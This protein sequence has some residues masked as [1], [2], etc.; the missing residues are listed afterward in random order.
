MDPIPSG[1]LAGS[2]H[3]L[4]ARVLRS[5]A[6]GCW[7]CSGVSPVVPF[8][9]CGLAELNLET[10]TFYQLEVRSQEPLVLC[11]C[12]QTTFFQHRVMNPFQ[13]V[14]LFDV[15]C[16]I[17]GFSLGSA[18]LGMMTSAFLDSNSLACETIRANFHAPVIQGSVSDISSVQQLHQLKTDDFSQLTSGFPCQ[19]YSCQGDMQGLRDKRGI[20]RDI[21]RCAWLLQ[22][23]S[24]LLECVDNVMK[25][26]ET[27]QLLDSY[28]EAVHMHIAKI[29][30]DL[31]DQWPTRR[32]RFW[33]LMFRDEIPELR[34]R[35]WP[36]C[37]HCRTLGDVMP[38][39][40]VWSDESE[41]ELA[42]TQVEM[43]V[44][45]NVQYGSDIRQL[46]PHHQAPT[47]LHSW[48][49]L[50]TACP[51]GC[52]GGP[53]S[54]F[55][56]E[57]G[58][59]RGF[60]IFSAKFLQMRH[61]HAEE[62]ALLCTVPLDYVFPPSQRAALCLLGQL[63]APLSVLW[64]QA[65]FLAHLQEHFWLQTSL[66]PLQL[67]QQYKTGLLQQR[68]HRWTLASMD[69]PRRISVSLDGIITPIAVCS[70]VTVGD[71]E[72]AE[73]KL[74]GW[75]H[76]VIVT[77]DHQR[78]PPWC[79]LHEH[80][81]YHLQVI[82]KKQSRPRPTSMVI[83][84][85]ISLSSTPPHGLGDTHIWSSMRMLLDLVSSSGRL[86]LPFI[87]YPFRAFHFL[88]QNI[89]EAVQHSWQRQFCLSDGSI[90]VIYE[91][92]GHWTLLIGTHRDGFHWR[93]FDG[94]PL[95]FDS[96][97]LCVAQQISAKLA[98]CLTLETANF[99]SA[100]SVLQTLPHTCGSIAL[101]NM[102]MHLQV[103]HHLS[104]AS[105]SQLHH[106]FLATSSHQ[107]GVV[108]LGKGQTHDALVPLLIGKGVPEQLAPERAQHIRDKLGAV[109]VQ[110]ILK[111]PNPWASLKAAASKPGKM[112]RLITEEEQ[113]D[114]VNQRALTKH[115]ARVQNP[116][117][118]KQMSLPKGQSVHLNPDLF[119]L[120][121]Q[122]FQ[123]A[124][125]KAVPQIPFQDVGADQHGLA[126]C[127]LE[128]AR[129]FL[130][131]PKSI[132]LSALALL[133]LDSPPAKLVADTGLQ[134]MV[135]PALC[136]TTAEHTIIMGHI[137]QLGDS[138]VRRKMAGK[139]SEPE[140]ILTQVMTFQVYKD[141]FDSDWD[142]LAQAPVRC[143]V[144]MM[145]AMQLCK[146]NNCGVDC[147]KYHPGIDETLD[148]VLSEV[149]SR[150]FVN[151]QGKRVDP[152]SATQFSVFVRVPESALIKILTTLPAGVYAEPRGKQPREQDEHFKVIWL[153]GATFSEASHQCRTYAKAV[154][155]VRLKNKYG[156][157]VRKT[158]EVAAWSKL[159]PGTDFVD[160]SIQKIYELFPIP[161]GTQRQAITQIL[162]DWSWKAR[163]LQPGKGN[164]HHMAWRVG[165]SM[166][167]PASV[168]TAFGSDVIISAVK[169]LQ[170]P[171]QKPQIYASAKTQKLLREQPGP[172][173]PSKATTNSDP[174]LEHDPWGSFHPTQP[175]PS[176][177][178]S[179]KAEL[180]E[181]VRTDIKS[182][183]QE[184]LTKHSEA[185]NVDLTGGYS[186]DSELRF[187][188]LETGLTELKHQ[189]GQFLQWFQQS[190]ERMQQA[191]ATMQD[192]QATVQ[193]H[194]S[195]LQQMSASVS[196]T[197]KALGEVHSTL[198]LHQQEI[199]A[200]GTNFSTAMRSMKEELSGEM[201]ESFNQQYGKP[202]NGFRPFWILAFLSLFGHF[203][204]VQALQTGTSFARHYIDS[205]ATAVGREFGSGKMSVFVQGHSSCHVAGT[206]IGEAHNP[207]PSTASDNWLS[208]GVSNP[209][210]LRSK[211]DM[212]L[213]MG[214]GIWTMT[215]TQLSAV[216]TKSS[217]RSFRYG[218][219]KLHR[220]VRPHYSHPAPLR[221]GSQWAGKWTGVCTISDWP[222]SPLQIAWPHEHW[223]TGRVL[224]T[225]HW[226]NNFPVTIGGFY[227]FAQGPT[228]PRA[229][230][231]SDQILETYTRE[232]V[233]GM[234]GVRLLVGDFNQDPEVLVQQQVWARH[235]WQN[236]QTLAASTLFHEWQPTCKFST[237]R[238]QIW[239]SPEAAQLLREL[240][241]HEHFADHLTLEIKLQVPMTTASI[242]RWPRPAQMPWADVTQTDWD[243]PCP[244]PYESSTDPTEFLSDWAKAYED[245]VSLNL[246]AN[247]HPPLQARCRGR[248]QRL[249]PASQELVPPICRPSREGEVCLQ[250]S[251]VGAAV[252]CWFK[253][254]RRLQSLCHSVK[255]G[256]TSAT[257]VSY[258][259]AVWT[260]ILRSNGF[261]P[262]FRTWWRQRESP[263]DGAPADLPE[264]LPGDPDVVH[265]IYLDFLHHFRAFET[266][267]LAQRQASLKIKYEGSLSSVYM[268]LRDD[269][270]PSID[271]VWKEEKYQILA[272]DSE[273]N[274]VM[275]D[276]DVATVCDSIW[277]HDG[278]RI[279]VSHVD[280]AVCRVHSIAAL[281]TEDEIVQRLF[282]TDVN[283]VLSA[284][285]AHWSNRWNLLSQLPEDEWH[286]IVQF[287]QAY[288]PTAPFELPQLTPSMWFK[289]VKTFKPRAARGP[290]GF[291]KADLMGMPE[292]FV[293]T[294]LAM[295]HSVESTVTP[296][297]TQLLFGTVLGLAKCKDAHAEQHY[298][299][300][301][302]FSILYRG[303]SRLRTKQLIAQLAK[304]MPPE[305]LGFLPHREAAEV[306]LC[307]QGQIEVMLSLDEPLSGLSSDMR[308]AFNHIGRRQ[309][310]HM[311]AH[312]GYPASLLNAWGKFLSC[313]VRRFDVRGCVG[314]CIA[315]NHG[316]PEGD[317]LSIV[318][319][320][321]VNWGYHIYMKQ[322]APAVQ[323][324]SFVD[325]L[326]LA[327]RN[328]LL[329]IQGYFAMLAYVALFGLTMDDEKTF[330][331]GLT[332]SARQTLQQLG[333]PCQYEAS[334]L[335]ASMS[336]GAKI[337]NRLIKARGTGMEDK[338]GKL[339][340]SPAPFP[341]KLLMLP[342]VFWPRALHGAPAC[343]FSDTYI[344]QLR[345]AA[346]K[347]L[348][349]NGAGSNPTLRLSLSDNMQNDPGFYQLCYCIS[350]LR[351]LARKSMDLLPMWKLWHRHFVG[352]MQPGPFTKITTCLNQIGWRVLDPP[353]IADHDQHT[354]N[355]IH[356]DD[357]TLHLLLQEAWCQFVASHTKHHTMSS[358]V[359]MDYHLTM[360]DS[361]KLPPL[362]RALVAAL[363]SGAFVSNSEH[364]KYDMEK[365]SKCLLCNCE[366]TRAHWLVCPRYQHLRLAIED[367]YPDNVELPDCTLHHLLVPRQ[368]ARVEWHHALLAIQDRT[369][370]FFFQPSD[371]EMHHLF[372][373]GSCT[374]PV[375]RCLSKAAW[376]VL[377]ATAGEPVA[378]GHLNGL[379]QTID[380]AELTALVAA[381][382]WTT[383]ADLCIWS[384]SLSTIN[385]AE[386][387]QA[388]GEVPISVEN[389][390]LW[391]EFL[392]ALHLRAGRQTLFRWIPSHVHPDQAEDPFEEWAFSWNHA[393]D[394]L[395]TSWNSQRDVH[396]LK[397][398]EALERNINWWSER[399]RQLRS[400]YFQ[401]AHH[402]QQKDHASSSE[403]AAAEP[404]IEIDSETDS[405]DL[406]SDGLPVNWQACADCHATSF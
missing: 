160:M 107:P 105:E 197:E 94:L 328:A 174:W 80:V 134:P 324:Y 276:R 239:L 303:W 183:I 254:L 41:H 210:G 298:R 255:A 342:R 375:H 247:Q 34:L 387:I 346:T 337:R 281:E 65:Q 368:L 33:C 211:E 138:P 405:F 334:E 263:C 92:L 319:M 23:D 130:E 246:V 201:M 51:C 141:Q 351:R 323:A 265:A 111:T 2:F 170:V 224:L 27:Q 205:S 18:P 383:V 278:C 329:V 312:L 199:H 78:L 40:A 257:A 287:T 353:W 369:K 133:I 154:C 14:Q 271:H 62:G 310:F 64:I 132:S 261:H 214:P 338:W 113:R 354:W 156:I 196:N 97:R 144:H 24:L 243:P 124:E 184:E 357:K 216:T 143:L 336:Y 350:I 208:I 388:H 119:Q 157:R 57:Q 228:W 102:A 374:V 47:M 322:Y 235:G 25:F 161:H 259:A 30:F 232:V 42:W 264:H 148:A 272:I 256:N 192:L 101:L 397:T 189:N 280:G 242:L 227:G 68:L 249:T 258:R 188:A 274:Q 175:G 352:K 217:A 73:T 76:Y 270:K 391:C 99:V 371:Q 365:F 171:E 176:V 150:S 29:V 359:G 358:L 164:F 332:T 294:F 63:A 345:R 204:P 301:T 50:F 110:Q 1:Q 395:V 382:S 299:P 22:V 187:T 131:N 163:A 339:R 296:W 404:I 269:T 200:V 198:N 79:L 135:F 191:D 181:Q 260:A 100:I 147:A 15:C 159:R 203:G 300:I 55:R 279:Q 194:A 60:G 185:M 392:D 153:P 96:D 288:M 19:P 290:D 90:Y 406:I 236:A 127:T 286:R 307:L 86:D 231:L 166:A 321:T 285:T 292:S 128:M 87:L 376:G 399:L 139:E 103:D 373:D 140:T 213:M 137:L 393:V 95:D 7:A 284:F 53:L 390:D 152:P 380:R 26:D 122:H 220:V 370:F 10:Y 378:L 225:R 206:R 341:Q 88:H 384:D 59:A 311:G 355:L 37:S 218:G 61:L 362:Q 178:R 400:F 234:S 28:A 230:H 396:F 67:L 377:S 356:L 115:G 333:F 168:M 186:T 367:W 16:G 93:Y 39:D 340:R 118:K 381:T 179:H 291:D 36:Q 238:D 98:H 82:A 293:L 325:N 364:A 349:I 348:Q 245:A 136:T 71:L 109:P 289:T 129:H 309:V 6:D 308:R 302:L 91:Y 58:G 9:L 108:A 43:D 12:D 207:G 315:S 314:N 38:F 402:T 389:Y 282:V 123:D 45:S 35:V 69:L 31:Q 317:P 158:D 331:W 209:G 229:R 268:D 4:V 195:T 89:H 215:E 343:V 372:T 347:A 305:V 233:L 3:S 5:E 17:G 320:L 250:S 165:S 221:Q 77:C 386:F 223:A 273:T 252:R 169:D 316:F 155:L 44:F 70:A 212:V 219:R 240:H 13:K 318:A 313:F 32:R 114:Y 335:G 327:A 226:I 167:P 262:N 202:L 193:G 116:K 81:L 306:W 283:D 52:R 266:W 403:P 363:Q 275:L 244:V 385:L 142:L 277:F 21:L 74:L 8:K 56:L 72:Q 398:S 106:F 149:W 117:H 145:E 66:D 104:F 146:G 75:G 344:M 125:G 295:L 222:S 267:H 173:N 379:I 304:F 241:L 366:D 83:G 172:S 121:A 237:E 126:L 401:V 190:G 360:L 177:S 248:A 326:T 46:L 297:P 394:E 85:G 112:F 49:N 180:Q 361:A 84:D 151:D 54:H 330:V 120:D 251:L 20:L 48:A 253:Q 162:A 182:A 11:S